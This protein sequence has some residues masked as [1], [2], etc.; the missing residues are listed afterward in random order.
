MERPDRDGLDVHP[1]CESA[2]DRRMEVAARG[3]KRRVEGINRPIKK[4]ID[5]VMVLKCG[6]L[7]QLTA[8]LYWKR[9]R[10]PYQKDNSAAALSSRYPGNSKYDRHY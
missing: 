10:W 6:V 5:G 1:L 2:R 3:T 7:S 4:E 8:E 9:D